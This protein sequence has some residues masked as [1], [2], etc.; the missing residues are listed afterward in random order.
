MPEQ[1]ARETLS[2]ILFFDE[3]D[4][5]QDVLMDCVQ[6]G[7]SLPAGVAAAS[8]TAGRGTHGRRWDNPGEGVLLSAAFRQKKAGDAYAGLAL[9]LSAGVLECLLRKGID[10]RLKWPNDIYLDGK[11]L[12]GLLVEAK[13]SSSGPVFIVGLGLNLKGADP[14]FASLGGR[15][16]DSSSRDLT[17]ELYKSLCAAFARCE[18]EGFEAVRPFWTAHALGVGKR[19][20][21]CDNTTVIARGIFTGVD[22][23][24]RAGIDDGTSVRYFSS[25]SLRNGSWR[26]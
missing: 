10:A 11:K 2:G 4:S 14:A 8:Q 12:A 1:G 5:T 24:G 20:K 3:V 18:R 21:L 22:A 13:K 6:A 15:L 9:A 17:V 25:G 23:H 26:F 19:A 7:A 16:S